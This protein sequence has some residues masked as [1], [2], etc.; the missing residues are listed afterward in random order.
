M[1]RNVDCCQSWYRSIAEPVSFDD[2]LSRSWNHKALYHSLCIYRQQTN[3]RLSLRIPCVAAYLLGLLS[4][5]PHS[6]KQ[7]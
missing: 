2:N 6:S 3:I 7:K 1:K 4:Q 5:V